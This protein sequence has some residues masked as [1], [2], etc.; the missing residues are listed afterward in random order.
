LVDEK[1]T[2]KTVR[3]L[4]EEDRAQDLVV[5]ANDRA[6]GQGDAWVI[7]AP[8]EEK[9]RTTLDKTLAGWMRP[10]LGKDPDEWHAR[11]LGGSGNLATNA[12]DV[13]RPLK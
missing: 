6:G 5:A 2:P 8:D 10:H 11:H 7:L 12:L 4:M 3:K 1:K 9:S 13:V